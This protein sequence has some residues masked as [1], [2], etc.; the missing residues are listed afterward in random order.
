MKERYKVL[1]AITALREFTVEDIANRTGVKQN[2]VST[3][4]ARDRGLLE[5]IADEKTGRRGGKRKR[6]RIKP[7][8]AES[9]NSE[10]AELYT[11]LPAPPVPLG[12]LAAEDTLLV[13]YPNGKNPQEKQRLLKLAKLD[14]Q[15]G[16]SESRRLLEAN[17]KEET[18][19]AVESSLYRVKALQKFFELDLLAHSL[20]A[21]HNEEVS[22]ETLKK[23]LTELSNGVSEAITDLNPVLASVRHFPTSK[24]RKSESSL[25]SQNESYTTATALLDQAS[26]ESDPKEKSALLEQAS[27]TLEFVWEHYEARDTPLMTLA[28]IRYEQGRLKFLR[29]DYENAQRLFEGAREVFATS[30]KYSDEVTKIDQHLAVLAVE[31]FRLTQPDAPAEIEIQTTF[32]ALEGIDSRSQANYPLIKFLQNQLKKTITRFSASERVLRR[33]LDEARRKFQPARIPQE[34]SRQQIPSMQ[35]GAGF[36]FVPM[37]HDR[38]RVATTRRVEISHEHRC[39]TPEAMELKRSVDLGAQNMLGCSS[40][41]E[42]GPNRTT[43]DLPPLLFDV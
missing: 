26:L 5:K 36:V 34:S 25:I 17:P 42:K 1:A 28:F 16:L 10:L 39:F 40:F 18:R 14:Y 21:D 12:L 35:N 27:K 15:K 20:A 41:D 43:Y 19:T 11:D 22:A 4:L 31:K 37:E 23:S 7:E 6:Y 29:Q 32:A 33:E 8:S 13:R 2:T 3:I 38:Y 9:L 30:E 24:L